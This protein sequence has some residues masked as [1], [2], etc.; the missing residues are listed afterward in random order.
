MD[1]LI[2]ASIGIVCGI[3]IHEKYDIE[4]EV[5]LIGV[6]LGTYLNDLYKK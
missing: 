1:L 4:T 5:F 2:C 3:I 6:A